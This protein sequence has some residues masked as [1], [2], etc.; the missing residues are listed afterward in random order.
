MVNR[1]LLNIRVIHLNQFPHAQ[2]ID[3]VITS[4]AKPHI[5]YIRMSYARIAWQICT[6]LLQVL[7][8]RSAAT[9]M[10]GHGFIFFLEERIMLSKTSKMPSHSISLSA[11]DCITGDKLAKVKG[12]VCHGCYA[13]KGRYNMPN[14][15]T[16]MEKRKVFF[17]SA[18]FVDTMI[19]LI[20]KKRT[21]LFRWFDSGDVQSV[22][23]AHNI[24]DVVRGTPDFKHWIP[25][26]EA[27][28]WKEAL[29]T[30]P[31]DMPSNFV[32]R[33][34]AT[35]VDGKPSKAFDNTST[36]HKDKEP[37]GFVCPAYTQGGKCLDCQACW[38][39]TV[40]NVSYKKH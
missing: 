10:Q 28:I 30:Y 7:F 14:V 12:S 26:K 18:Q 9:A 6:N 15:K 23:M 33:I 25:S 3:Y 20:S 2:P 19:R 13:R 32:L 38:D 29:A 34:S 21:K 11:Y 8:T 22:K 5:L 31:N 36:V 39:K 17:Q 37:I 1:C 27:K 40:K 16:S 4:H 35:M 24:L